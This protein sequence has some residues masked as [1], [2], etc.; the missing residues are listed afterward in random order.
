MKNVK[1]QNKFSIKPVKLSRFGKVYF[2]IISICIVVTVIASFFNENFFSIRV[3]FSIG[4][5]MSMAAIIAFAATAV[6]IVKCTDLSIGSNL[7]FS[8]MVGALAVQAGVPAIL[9]MVLMII[10]GSCAGAINGFLISYLNISPFIATFAMMQLLRGITILISGSRSIP[11]KDP[12]LLWLGASNILGIPVSIILTLVFLAI[13]SFVMKCTVYGRNVYAVGGNFEAA[14]ASGINSKFIR[15]STLVL[16]GFMVGVASI[17]YLGRITSAQPMAGFGMEF[18]VL[19]A[20]F[21]G[22]ALVRGGEGKPLGALLGTLLVMIIKTAMIFMGVTQF[23]SYIVTGVFIL[24]AV[25]CYQEDLFEN[26]KN[27]YARFVD[28]FKN[29]KISVKTIKN[30]K[31]DRSVDH[32]M[33]LHEIT[34]KFSGFTALDKVSTTIKSGEII[35]LIGENGAGKSTFV[36]VMS[37]VFEP[38]DGH[39]VI[40]GQQRTFFSPQDSKNMGIGVIHQHYSLIPELD[41]AQNIFYNREPKVFGLVNRKQMKIQARQLM[42]EFNLDIPVETKVYQLTVGQR[43]LVEVVK[44][45]L[46][47]PWLMIM[48]EPTS[49]L[50]K[51]ESERLYELIDQVLSK[52]VAIIYISHKM[53]EVFKLCQR[54]IVLRDGCKVCEVSQLSDI[55]E[56]ELVNMMVGREIEH[57]FPYTES[58]GTGDVAMEIEHLS[59]GGILK[60]VS[61]KVHNGELVVLA[62]LMG[63]GR[64]EA[65]ECI[66]GLRNITRGKVL[67]NGKQVKPTTRNMQKLS[68]G[69]IPEDRHKDGIVPHMSIADNLSLIWN[70]YYSKFG[71]VEK[72]GETLLVND[73]IS[74]LNIKPP[75]PEKETIYLSGGNQQKVVLGKF[76]AISPKIFIL[77]DPTRGVDVGAKSEIHEIISNF[78]KQGV[79]I[80]LISSELPELLN[81]ADRIYVLHNGKTVKELPHGTTESEVMHYAFGL[82]N[83]KVKEDAK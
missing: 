60:D 73:M 67:I 71:I 52:N 65:V 49:S 31:A 72:K 51:T 61:F 30:M 54:A 46:G 3:F 59:D 83:E 23:I 36:N 68:M 8:A 55:T 70:R 44:A 53:S 37:G 35:G 43:Q 22:G 32:V 58:T 10:A 6:V 16:T 18:E 1:E 47:D 42:S 2:I 64:T 81:V 24:F 56:S 77:D 28:Q 80:L 26:L 7:A 15:F 75:N 50:S 27:I 38:T 29:R 79:A 20:V 34:K 74:Q 9:C 45:T 14:R 78:K 21:V 41:I 63:A 57:I 17:L 39:I 19:T 82:H 76:V 12:Q 4:N 66:Y 48:D 69:F 5:Q 25:L 62:G 33:E 11:I 40:D 13:W